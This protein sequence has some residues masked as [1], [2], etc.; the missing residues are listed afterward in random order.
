MCDHILLVL[1]FLSCFPSF[2]PL[3]FPLVSLL[4]F[5]VFIAGSTPFMKDRPIRVPSLNQ[6]MRTSISLLH[7]QPPLL[8]I[9]DQLLE[10]AHAN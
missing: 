1:V 7:P 8:Y 5:F 9:L 3:C 10:L 4:V 6:V 2:S